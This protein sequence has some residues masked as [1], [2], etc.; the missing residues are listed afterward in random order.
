MYDTL[1]LFTAIVAPNNTGIRQLL[2]KLLL[3]VGRY[4]FFETQCMCRQSDS[5]EAS[6]LHA[7]TADSEHDDDKHQA[8]SFHCQQVTL[9]RERVRLTRLST[10]HNG[11]YQLKYARYLLFIYLLITK[12]HTGYKQRTTVKKQKSTETRTQYNLTIG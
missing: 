7:E 5:N 9:E 11:T 2:L 3:A 10:Q 8:I 4:T 1:L 6:N 12:S